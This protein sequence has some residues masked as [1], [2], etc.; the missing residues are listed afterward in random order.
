M[1]SL[2]TRSVTLVHQALETLGFPADQFEQVMGVSSESA[3][4]KMTG[5]TLPHTMNGNKK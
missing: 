4:G 3:S 2:A 1:T 5:F